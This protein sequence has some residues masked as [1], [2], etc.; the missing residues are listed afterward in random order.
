MSAMVGNRMDETEAK[1]V[2]TKMS[3]LWWVWLVTGITWVLI[4]LIILQFD[5]QSVNTIGILIGCMFLLTGVQQFVFAGLSSGGLRLLW[6]LFGVL[7]V[8][9][10]FVAIFNPE[11]TFSA[12]ADVLGFLFLLVGVFW[13]IE[14]LTTKAANP[15]WWLG[16]V[17]GVLMIMLAFWS[18][19][20]TFTA[21][22]YMLLVFAGIWAL[23]HGITDITKAFMVRALGHEL[24]DVA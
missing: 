1:E 9:G 2:L 3:S 21:R 24:R 12:V 4:S 11:D 14:A 19:A 16:L 15:L 13:L 20:Q 17:S 8:I 10:G 23:L 7:F 6:T 5:D 18:S 22:A